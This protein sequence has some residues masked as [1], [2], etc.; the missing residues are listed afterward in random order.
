MHTTQFTTSLN[1]DEIKNRLSPLDNFKIEEEADNTMTAKVGNLFKYK[2]IG[3]YLTDDYQAP[4]SIAAEENPD[5]EV[6]T[7]VQ[8][9]A[10]S[11]ELVDTKKASDFYERGFTEIRELLEAK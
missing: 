7:T 8:V 5:G 4:L 10:R 11:N 9:S 6:S 2:M 1:I 3:V